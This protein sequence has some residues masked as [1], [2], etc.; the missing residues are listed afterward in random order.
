MDKI[1]STNSDE[2]HFNDKTQGN[3]K[4]RIKQKHIKTW[5]QFIKK[6][7]IKITVYDIYIFFYQNVYE[8]QFGGR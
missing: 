6:I 7:K 8:G 2:T 1:S 4:I 5:D 3:I